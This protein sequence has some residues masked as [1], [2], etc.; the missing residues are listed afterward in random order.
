MDWNDAEVDVN[1]HLTIDDCPN[2]YPVLRTLGHDLH[3]KARFLF[4]E[5][6]FLPTYQVVKV[7]GRET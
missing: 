2:G 1:V 7:G 6:R 4:L 3:G 5:L